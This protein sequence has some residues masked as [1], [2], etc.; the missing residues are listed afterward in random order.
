[1]KLK[2][3]GLILTLFHLLILITT[4]HPLFS[5]AWWEESS[6]EYSYDLSQYHFLIVLGE[7]PDFHETMIIKKHWENWGAAVDMA[8]T[9]TELTGH[10]WKK[11]KKGWDRSEKRRIKTDLLISQVDLFQYQALFFPGG[12]SPKSLLKEDSSQVVQLIQ[13][14]NRKGLVLAAICHGPRVLAAANVIHDRKVTGHQD[15]ARR[16]TDAGGKVVNKVCVVDGNIIT[17]NWPYFG[18]M[19]ANVAEKL[20]YPDGGGPTEHSPFATNTVLKTIKERRSVRKFEDTNVESDKIETLLRAATWAPSANNDQPWKFVVCRNEEIKIQIVNALIDTMKE[21][22]ETK[23]VSLER[24]RSYWSNV[25]SAPVHIFAFCDTRNIE[26]DEEWRE[27]EML[28]NIQG[29]SVACQNILLAAKAQHLGSL[30]MGGT[31]VVE[32]NIKSLLQAPTQVKLVA[33]IAIGYPTHEPLPPIRRPLSETV[34]Y[35]NWEENK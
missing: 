17:G 34:A 15:V 26:M 6:E 35:E 2:P 11:A 10:V 4:G 22:Y 14:A 25:F 24:M 1:M 8:G 13:K 18:T 28:H 29:V 16:L 9:E 20:L 19:A 3:C 21:Y 5:Q 27:I 12:N 31:L 23:G 7:D 33:T 32:D 30:W